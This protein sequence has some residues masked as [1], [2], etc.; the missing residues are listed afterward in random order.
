MVAVTGSCAAFYFGVDLSKW[1]SPT[2]VC[3]TPGCLQLADRLT[4]SI[5]AAVNP[6]DDFY[7]FACGGIIGAAANSTSSKLHS[8]SNSGAD[9]QGGMLSRVHAI[10]TN[11]ALEDKIQT[12]LQASASLYQGC[13]AV[14][15]G[16]KKGVRRLVRF[17]QKCRLNFAKAEDLDTE[18][19]DSALNLDVRYNVKTLFDVAAEGNQLLV[20]PRRSLDIWSS[21]RQALVKKHTYSDYLENTFALLGFPTR[22]KIAFM[23]ASI[24]ETEDAVLRLFAGVKPDEETLVTFNYVEPGTVM[25]RPEWK[26]HLGRFWDRVAVKGASMATYLKRL[27]AD[28]TPSA[29]TQYVFW[30]VVRQLGP[31]ADYRLRF[32]EESVHLV[33]DRCFRVVY[34]VA[35]LVPL[36]V[37]LAQEVSTETILSAAS[38]LTR[39]VRNL[40][41]TNMTIHVVDPRHLLLE[42]ISVWSKPAS[43]PRPGD[44]VAADNS[45]PQMRQ[46]DEDGAFFD[47]YLRF[48]WTSRERELDLLNALVPVTTEQDLLAS[49]CAVD[50]GNNRVTVPTSMLLQPWFSPEVPRSFNYAG[51]GFAVVRELI[52]AGIHLKARFASMSTL[53][54]G[55]CNHTARGSDSR[56]LEALLRVLGH[57]GRERKKLRLPG[58]LD[59]MSEEQLFFL[60]YCTGGCRSSDGTDSHIGECNDV[61]RST[62]RFGSSFQCVRGVHMNPT[63]LNRCANAKPALKSHLKSLFSGPFWHDVARKVAN[64]WPHNRTLSH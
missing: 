61:L 1:L 47:F 60:A 3:V 12:P 35:G 2:R 29:I 7:R 41:A 51:L 37:V 9:F 39:I 58:L 30:E 45:W 8:T 64:M 23:A 32:P 50:V 27:F 16:Q 6:C 24:W 10:L 21:Q 15:S 59:S 44:V 22:M 28:L 13:I 52:R 57:A 55:D 14:V 19:L 38:F 34:D 63:E 43:S 46:Y 31:L 62:L 42:T 54:G 4:A 40:G 33:E 26:G 53:A 56:A 11:W 5:D 25:D 17:L 49:R 48:L 20:R 36:A 18:P